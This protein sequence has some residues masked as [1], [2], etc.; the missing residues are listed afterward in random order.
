MRPN[1]LFFGVVFENRTAPV[2]ILDLGIGGSPSIRCAPA[3]GSI[4]LPENQRYPL[5][6]NW[7][8]EGI[9]PSN[10]SD[11]WLMLLHSVRR[12]CPTRVWLTT[13]AFQ[14]NLAQQ[15]FNSLDGTA[16]N[17]VWWLLANLFVSSPPHPIRY[18]TSS[19]SSPL[20]SSGWIVLG[21]SMENPRLEW[22][23]GQGGVPKY[24]GSTL[25]PLERK[26]YCSLWS[27]P[28][29]SSQKAFCRSNST[30]SRMM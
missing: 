27:N 13:E 23:R 22:K 29:P 19:H 11:L 18:A 17:Q 3:P 12:Q 21:Y 7:W 15:S 26:A 14:S 1:S 20:P 10:L 24:E 16:A 4:E 25:R 9:S 30:R 5:A 28:R 6:S 8:L 2:T